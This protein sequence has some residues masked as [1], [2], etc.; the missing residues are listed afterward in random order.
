MDTES[1]VKNAMPVK[2]K[3]K[4]T[5]IIMAILALAG[6]AVYTVS[7]RADRSS[8]TK[9]LAAA[10]QEIREAAETLTRERAAWK[11]AAAAITSAAKAQSEACRADM[12]RLTQIED[13]DRGCTVI[14]LQR[15]SVDE[16]TSRK[17]IDMF[18]H[19]L[20]AP[21]GGVRGQAD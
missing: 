6:W 4:I 20:F 2:T 12:E 16:N 13:I 8:L 5:M 21:M 14:E 11:V 10:R 19:S 3:I 15:G 9:Q 17:I 18:N 1:Q 7:I